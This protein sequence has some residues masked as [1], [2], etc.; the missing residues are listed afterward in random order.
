[1]PAKIG[2]VAED[3]RARVWANIFPTAHSAVELWE[4]FKWHSGRDGCDTWQPNSSQALA[5]DFFGTLRAIDQESRD[6]VFGRIA[7][8]VGLSPVGPWNI[9][10]E[11][12]DGSN[13]L[14]ESGSVHK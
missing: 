1:M 6:L 12:E 3:W 7:S 5:I 9:E 10:L 13:L 2:N 4:S 14:K 8:D 11:W